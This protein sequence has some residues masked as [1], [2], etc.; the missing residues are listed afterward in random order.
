[1]PNYLWILFFIYLAVFLCIIGELLRYETQ[2]IIGGV[3]DLA[4]YLATI[5][6]KYNS[7]KDNIEV[8]IK[9]TQHDLFDKIVVWIRQNKK[10][11]ETNTTNRIWHG[12]GLIETIDSAGKS[13]WSRKQRITKYML[14][15]GKLT[16][17]LEQSDIEVDMPN[18]KPDMIRTKKRISAPL[19][20]YWRIDC[21]WVNDEQ[22]PEIEVEY[23]AKDY[24]NVL[25]HIYEIDE[26]LANLKN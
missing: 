1:M 5:K 13:E 2:Y 26:F 15:I 20:K 3:F 25:R 19:N 8:E 24:W 17:A 4:S 11:I 7:K 18:I 23:I 12:S 16:V 10:N 9:L 22:M 14:P 21:T 6:K